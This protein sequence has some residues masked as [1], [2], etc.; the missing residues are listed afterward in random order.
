MQLRWKSRLFILMMAGAL[1]LGMTGYAVRAAENG[2]AAAGTETSSGQ[3]DISKGTFEIELANESYT[4]SGKPIEPE[5]S[6]V[7][8]TVPK[9]PAEDQTDD[10]GSQTG[11]TSGTGSEEN[12]GNTEDQTGGT[13]GGDG[14]TGETAGGEDQTGGETEENDP[15]GETTGDDSQTGGKTEE[16]DQT[17]ETTGEDSQTGEAAGDSEKVEF[18]TVTLKAD[19]YTVK[20][21]DNTDAGTAVVQVTGKGDYTGTIETT[22][23]IRKKDIADFEMQ[24]KD[25]QYKGRPLSADVNM[26]YNDMKLERSK[27]YRIK[28]YV[29]NENVGTASATV[30]GKGNYTG[31]RTMT[32]EITPVNLYDLA[33][34]PDLSQMVYQYNGQYLTPEVTFT[35]NILGEDNKVSGQKT[36][37]KDVDYTI[38]YADNQKVGVAGVMVIGKGN[39][40]GS[41]VMSFKIRPQN[42]K[43]KK[44]VKGKK[45]LTAKW[46]KKDEQVTGY[47][48]MCSRKKDFSSD[49][50]KVRVKKNT[51]KYT[52]KK[53]KSKKKYFVRVRTYKKVAGITYYSDWSN[54]MKIKTK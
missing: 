10:T 39:F 50:K 30:K 33:Y 1:S 51:K 41:R 42:T 19:D 44:L 4:Y 28:D 35:F 36:L 8:V 15:N 6:K 5:I 43:L 11:D 17:G 27:D 29:N 25:K 16:N 9:E 20:Y 14:Q 52:F 24:G 38:T 49:V 34:T 22:F 47:V 54:V 26:Y 48:V 23:T 46:A 18:E 21:K 12:T 32:F 3:T 2:N 7:T 45:K 53:L 37:V 40:S 13:T 31:E